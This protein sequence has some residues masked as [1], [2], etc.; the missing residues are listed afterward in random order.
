VGAIPYGASFGR[1][2]ATRAVTLGQYLDDMRRQQ[3]TSDSGGI[4]DRGWVADYV[5]D[6]PGDRSAQGAGQ[7]ADGPRWELDPLAA[8]LGVD[9]AA[10]LAL[11]TD[12]P[13]QA[14]VILPHPP[15]R[16]QFYVGPAGTGAPM[17]VHK[18][19]INYLAWGSKQWFLARPHEVRVRMTVPS[20]SARDIPHA[21]LTCA[22]PL[23][24]GGV[25]HGT[26]RRVGG[27][28]GGG[29]DIVP[30]QSA[31]VAVQAVGG[32]CHVCAGRVGTCSAEH[33]GRGGRGAGV[34][35]RR[36]DGLKGVG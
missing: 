34:Q 14:S 33:G 10:L 19:A 11:L 5:F 6:A 3:S 1:G 35:H 4:D 9:N 18:D 31:G 20:C 8:A 24:A 17:H 28:G 22:P 23:P 15:V 30:R 32:R 12:V 27:G 36:H 16:P 13:G 25:L 26:H 29:G 21:L 2:N 7:S